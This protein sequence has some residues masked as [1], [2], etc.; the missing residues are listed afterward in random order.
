MLT[1]A[2]RAVSKQMLH[3]NVPLLSGVLPRPSLDPDASAPS[4]V[5]LIVSSIFDMI[6]MMAEGRKL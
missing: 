3:S 6:D 2:S 5:V 1:T 4:P